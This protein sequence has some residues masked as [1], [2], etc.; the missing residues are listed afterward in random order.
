MS[1]LSTQNFCIRGDYVSRANA[2]TFVEDGSD[3]WT[4][5]RIARSGIYQYY[6]YKKASDIL[7][8]TTNSSYLDV[9]CGYP[10]KIEN[11]IHPVTSNI[12][13]IDQP[14]MEE[15]I[16]RAFPSFRFISMDLEN[17]RQDLQEQFDC[18]C[19]SDVI[20]HLLNP[21]PLMTFIR[22]VTKPSGTILISTPERDMQRGHDCLHSPQPEHVREWTSAEFSDYLRQ[23]G[24]RILEHHLLPKG[25][26]LG[27][28]EK[29]LP[30]IGSI[31]KKRYLSCQL[32]VCK[33]T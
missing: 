7:R 16:K 19:A 22:R 29:L 17:P 10:K 1:D 6:V 25:R 11:F 2:S 21:D 27:W 26:L 18:V 9:G 31:Y 5:A 15:T 13:V 14:S 4:Q 8:V 3:Y 33:L 23:H 20:E 12:T 28:E 24:F 30:L 32:V